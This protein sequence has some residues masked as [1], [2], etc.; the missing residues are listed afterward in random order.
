M[1]FN[2]T[3]LR[4]LKNVTRPGATPNLYQLATLYFALGDKDNG[5]KT[6]TRAFDVQREL[7]DPTT[8]DP[9]FD[10]VRSDPRMQA[11]IARLKLPQYR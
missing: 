3:T 9:L 4:V 10:D 1:K 8:I 7:A 6:L 2:P 5:F 11:L